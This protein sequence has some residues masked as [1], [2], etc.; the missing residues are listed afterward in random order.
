MVMSLV[1]K[2]VGVGQYFDIGMSCS[3]SYYESDERQ[4]VP[5]IA[6][7]IFPGASNLD[8]VN[9]L[10]DRNLFETPGA[11]VDIPALVVRANISGLAWGNVF[12][13]CWTLRVF[14]DIE[15]S[16]TAVDSA[17]G[18]SRGGGGRRA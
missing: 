13:H 4:G 11:G 14:D 6:I 18:T 17:S 1:M 12:K 10:K 15:F 7:P 2:I 5:Y 16:T 3:D 8:S 9:V